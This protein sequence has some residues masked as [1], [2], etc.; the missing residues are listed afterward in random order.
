VRLVRHHHGPAP[1]AARAETGSARKTAPH[2]KGGVVRPRFRIWIEAYALALI[3]GAC[4]AAA[5]PAPLGPPAVAVWDLEDLGPE[6]SA[7]PGLG[8]ALAGRVIQVLDVE[9]GYQVIE[10]E[11]LVRILEELNLGSGELADEETRL[12][13]GRIAGAQRMVFGSYLVIEGTARIDLRLVEVETGRVLAAAERSAAG[14]DI[15]A[16]LGAAG[17]A[18]AELARAAPVRRS[19]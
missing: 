4:A 14:R 1:W 3:L 9:G 5:P 16:W 11:R 6:G 8:E 18:A 13:L 12:R 19:R 17:E 15:Q 10:R 7:L 2:S